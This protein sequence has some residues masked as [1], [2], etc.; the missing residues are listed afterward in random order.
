[1]RHQHLANTWLVSALVLT[2]GCIGG[3]T[4]LAAQQVPYDIVIRNGRVLDGSGNPFILADVAI[5]DGRFV[6][7]GMVRDKEIGRAHV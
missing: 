5:R 1:M 7:V 4:P 3:V 6:K 2:F